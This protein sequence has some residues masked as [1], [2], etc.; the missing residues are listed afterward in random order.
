MAFKLNGAHQLLVYADDFN[1]LGGSIDTMRK[2]TE[3]L[4]IT[5]KGTSLEV[6]AEKTKY[7]VMSRDQ[8]AGQN[9]KYK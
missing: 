5:S 7:I 3:A 8:N 9:S 1:I 2:N 4:L 6:N